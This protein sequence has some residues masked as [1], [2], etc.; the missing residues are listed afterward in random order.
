MSNKSRRGVEPYPHR[1]ILVVG[2]LLSSFFF[3]LS[4][5]FF[6]STRPVFQSAHD[7]LS[8]DVLSDDVLSDDVLKFLFFNQGVIV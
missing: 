4:S 6:S 2:S 7:V 8:D 5:S 1:V 3:L